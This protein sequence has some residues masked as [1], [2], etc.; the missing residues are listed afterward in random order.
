MSELLATIVYLL[1][2]EQ[3]QA[4]SAKNGASVN[5]DWRQ[6]V[7]TDKSDETDSDD[8]SYVYVESFIDV[9]DDTSCLDRETFLQLKAFSGGCGKYYEYVLGSLNFIGVVVLT[10]CALLLLQLLP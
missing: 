10:C 1:Y 8:A 4:Q 6:S 3:W 7:S 9:D 5:E 2:I